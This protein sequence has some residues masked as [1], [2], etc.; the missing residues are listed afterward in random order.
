[1]K[2]LFAGFVGGLLVFLW[3]A[4]SHMLLPLG[5]M[6]LSSMQD[7]G[8]EQA[9]LAEMKTELGK[10]GLY[11]LPS[12]GMNETGEAEQEAF[13]ARVKAGPT[14]FVVFHPDGA[15]LSGKQFG[16][17][18]I[19]DV[20]AALI[21]AFVVSRMPESMFLTRVFVVA[22][23]GVFAWLSIEA[24]HWIWYRFPD[25]YVLAQAIDQTAGWAI[26]GVAIAVMITGKES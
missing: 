13:A 7:A 4:V 18:F 1:M 8:K 12:A 19:A 23:L 24:S 10:P 16:L 21:A 9:L 6:G 25:P 26:A 5:Q 15:E 3:G 14:G 22:L 2:V 11:I 20:L 17:E